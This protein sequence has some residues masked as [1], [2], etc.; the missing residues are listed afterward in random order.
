MKREAPKVI[1][2]PKKNKKDFDLLREDK[3]SFFYGREHKEI[4]LIAMAY[5]FLNSNYKPLGEKHQGGHFRVDTL[6]DQDITL[7]KAIAAKK[8]GSLDI[9]LNLK[10]VYSI[11]E[12]YAAGG[13]NY[14][15]NDVF[16]K[17][18]GSYSKKLE[19]LLVEL[20]KKIE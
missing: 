9:L 10:E 15:K 1:N 4:F 2:V 7:I 3:G 6:K 11:A 5:G 16:S 17:Q 19:E 20:Y 18:H 12:Q 13:I 8:T 14:L